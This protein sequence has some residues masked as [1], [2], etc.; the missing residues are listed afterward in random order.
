MPPTSVDPASDVL[1][2]TQKKNLGIVGFHT[3]VTDRETFEGERG[4]WL[5]ESHGLS[6]SDLCFASVSSSVFFGLQVMLV[7]MLLLNCLARRVST[8]CFLLAAANSSPFLSTFPF[9]LLPKRTRRCFMSL[10]F[11]AS[12][13]SGLKKSLISHSHLFFWSS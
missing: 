3:T 10:P 2:H 5:L 6:S 9:A 1:N 13:S 11:V 4:G 7:S 12:V 8:F